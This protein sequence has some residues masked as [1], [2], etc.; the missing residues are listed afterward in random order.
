MCAITTIAPYLCAITTI[1]P[2]LCAITISVYVMVSLCKSA[3]QVQ[4]VSAYIIGQ[5]HLLKHTA[6]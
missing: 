6:N 5:N 2:Y 1:A 4:P 3:S